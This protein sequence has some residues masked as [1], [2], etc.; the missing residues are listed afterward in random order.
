MHGIHGAREVSQNAVPRGIEDPTSMRSDEAID[1]D[2]DFVQA[3]D[4]LRRLK[5]KA[6]G[7]AKG[8]F[9]SRLLKK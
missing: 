3:K 6:A 5:N 4:E 1:D 8:G 2:P 9:L 7:E